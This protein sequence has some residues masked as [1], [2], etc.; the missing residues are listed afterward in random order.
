MADEER[1]TPETKKP[2]EF[3]LQRKMADIGRQTG[4]EEKRCPRQQELRMWLAVARTKPIKG[5]AQGE[6]VTEAQFDEG[7]EKA[8][9]HDPHKHA[10]SLAPKKEG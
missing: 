2:I 9:G 1:I 3:W 6:E 4:L 5:W 8:K 10:L 7:I